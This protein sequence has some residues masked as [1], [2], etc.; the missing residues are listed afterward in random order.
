MKILKY[1]KAIKVTKKNIDLK[2]KVKCDEC[3]TIFLIDNINDLI[4]DNSLCFECDSNI[5][6]FKSECPYCENRIFLSYFKCK[7]IKK[8]MDMTCVD[9]K[10]VRQLFMPTAAKDLI[11]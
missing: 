8:W 6:C 10:N 9:I 5:P 2:V 1:P 11:F 7:K 4:L 3:G